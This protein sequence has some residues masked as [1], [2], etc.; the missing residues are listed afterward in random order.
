EQQNVDQQTER[1]IVAEPA[2]NVVGREYLRIQVVQP[3]ANS[4]EG[5]PEIQADIALR[6]GCFSHD[7]L[8]HAVNEGRQDV[9]RYEGD[10]VHG[11]AE[12]PFDVGLVTQEIL[13]LQVQAAVFESVLQRGDHLV[14]EG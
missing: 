9:Q 12:D 14:E 3:Q 1:Q 5:G 13:I 6:S 8:G 4:D 7:L 10:F 11:F 2:L